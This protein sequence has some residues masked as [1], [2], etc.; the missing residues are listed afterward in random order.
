MEYNKFIYKINK[1]K[2]Y[3]RDPKKKRKEHYQKKIDFYYNK[4]DEIVMN[5]NKQKGGAF[6]DADLMNF[7]EPTTNELN[8]MLDKKAKIQDFQQEQ[9]KYEENHIKIIKFLN[10]LIEANDWLRQLD[11]EADEKI[12]KIEEEMKQMDE[13]HRQEIQD[14][15]RQIKDKVDQQKKLS[16]EDIESKYNIKL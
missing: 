1:Y 6:T 7:I 5:I 10:E 16:L 11:T 2:S 4:I 12:K 13:T 3:L 14:K 9:Q 15:L 8:E